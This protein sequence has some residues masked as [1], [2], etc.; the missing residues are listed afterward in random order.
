LPLKEHEKV[1]ITINT[2][3][4]AV[5]LIRATSGMLGWKGDAETVERVAMDPDFGV[6]ESGISHFLERKDG[7]KCKL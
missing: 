5:D 3:I 7:G 6:A 4:N 2:A 1:H